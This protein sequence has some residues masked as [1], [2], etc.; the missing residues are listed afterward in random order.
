MRLAAIVLALVQSVAAISLA[1]APVP[2]AKPRPAPMSATETAELDRLL[3][4][5]RFEAAERI[6]ERRIADGDRDP[7][8]LY[9]SACVLAQLGKLGAAEKRLLDA[10][11][12]G[13][14]DFDTME[15][16]PDLEPVRASDTYGAIMEAR[17]RIEAEH[18][19]RVKARG[20]SAPSRRGAA[21]DPVGQWK[22][23]H[24][25]PF[26]E[27]SGYR[28]ERDPDSSITY[29][30]FLDESS[31]RRMREMLDELER[32]LVSSYFGKPPTDALLVAIVRPDDAK[33]YLERPEVKG[34]YL[35]SARR[36]VSRDAGQSLQHEFVHLMHFSHMERTGQRHPIWVQEGLASLYEDYT[37]RADG[38]IE[39]HPNIR[40]N[41]A[42]K[43]VTSRT[44]RS[45]RELF[46]LNGEQF[47]DDAERHYPQVR[48][49]F[50][51]FAREGKLEEFYRQLGKTIDQDPSASA[52]V[53]KAFGTPLSSVEDRWRKWMVERGAVDDRIERDDASF[54][55]VISDNGDGVRIKSFQY[56]SAARAAGLRVDDI[57]FEVDALP[58]RNRD[59]MLMAVARLVV[60]REVVVRY[61][62]DDKEMSVKITPRPLGN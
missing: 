13:F 59:E 18:G 33:Q 49:I 8:L 38:S 6:L 16:D 3:Q 24:P 7:I 5:R 48:A 10:I 4:A 17:A 32:H 46:E 58:V 54:G 22:R 35:H 1:Q 21:P 51:F 26:D 41:F 37:L 9:N 15:G 25:Q 61:K 42:R 40:F 44:A 47:M 62:R 19:E 28:Y 2:P 57:I 14:R 12:S 34:M 52:A 27:K 36:L 29:A 20:P 45:W 55:I 50:E 60:G 56:K 23:D 43:Q 31:H 30:T 39:F 53:E 11:K